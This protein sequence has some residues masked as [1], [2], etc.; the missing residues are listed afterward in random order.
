VKKIINAFLAVLLFL[1]LSCLAK[2]KKPLPR[3]LGKITLGLP[4]SETGKYNAK[5]V[6]KDFKP[7][8]QSKHEKIFSFPKRYAP[9]H[10]DGLLANFYKDRLWRLEATFPPAYTKKI[11]WRKFL[12]QAPCEGRKSKKHKTLLENSKQHIVSWKDD[13]TYITYT[14]D[15]FLKPRKTYYY[16][17]VE[18]AAIADKIHSDNVFKKEAAKQQLCSDY[19][20][21]YVSG[22][23][24]LRQGKCKDSLYYF[25]QAIKHKP[26]NAGAWHYRAL[27]KK[28][29][30]QLNY[31]KLD[32]K[33][34]TQLDISLKAK[35]NGFGLPKDEFK[36]NCISH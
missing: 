3:N 36:I 19:R 25:T 33:K 5:D 23:S 32:F 35:D 8:L 28:K 30:G 6:T 12:K 11:S 15:E 2:T 27:A 17:S 1:N 26:E 31:S 7:A 34:A 14:K 29:L 16:I 13:F 9:Q 4:I 22:K 21:C 20:S 18:D 10:T 24:L